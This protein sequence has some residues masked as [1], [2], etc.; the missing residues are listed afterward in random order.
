[1][2]RRERRPVEPGEFQDPLENYDQPEY[3]DVFERS[4]SEDTVQ[5]VDS[6]PFTAVDQTTTVEQVI[7]LMAGQ[8]I[9]S[10]VIVDHRQRPV[11]IISERDVL[12]LIATDYASQKDLPISDVMTR[13]P[14]CVYE[15]DSPAQVL[16]LMGTGGFRHVP[17]VDTDRKLIGVIGVR[18]MN[19]YLREQLDRED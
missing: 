17:V 6:A 8:D 12:N 9:A 15:T 1:M 14:Y 10:A 2:A 3:A 11:G 19:R 7:E 5:Q 4:L 16:N 13:D 18:R